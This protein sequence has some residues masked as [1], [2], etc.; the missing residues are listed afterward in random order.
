MMKTALITGIAGQDGSYLAE[1][2]LEKGYRIIGSSRDLTMAK[3]LLPASL[4]NHVELLCWD[5]KCQEAVEQVLRDYKVSELYNFASFSSGSGMFDDAEAIGDINGLAVT[6]ILEAI[7]RVDTKI[8]FAQA[9]SSEIFGSASESP[10]TEE[11]FPN[12]RSPYG[13][14]K[15][16]ADSMIRIYRRHHG[17]FVCSAIL[18]NHESPRRGLGFVTR[19]ITHTAAKIKLR[20]AN[21]LTLGNLDAKRDWGFA[22]DY[23]RAIW[24][25]LQQQAAD[26]YVVATGEVN[27]VRELCQ[28][29]FSHVGLD[30]S[31][32]VREDSSF[33]RPLEPVQLVGDASKAKSVLDWQPQVKLRQLV[34]MMVDAD[35]QQL[36][37]RS[38]S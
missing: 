2:L 35:L 24:L 29:A 6:R 37:E 26:D 5:L 16:Y 23:V 9:S 17:L 27:S 18:F 19:K 3:T 25:M 8:R 20:L 4:T 14:A 34:G 10:Q 30:Y 28:L 7:R 1:L 32:Y 36:R 22:G 33:Y 38:N 15:L 31:D 21:E 13:S 12:P 11:T